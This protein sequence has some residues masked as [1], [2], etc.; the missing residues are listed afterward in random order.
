MVCSLK[1]GLSGASLSH[2]EEKWVG[3]REHSLGACAYGERSAIQALLAT[4]GNH[5]RNLP[6]VRCRRSKPA[7]P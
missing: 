2:V 1:F 6:P 7:V 5:Q 3:D 4:E